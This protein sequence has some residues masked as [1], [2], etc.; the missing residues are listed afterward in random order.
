MK[1]ILPDMKIILDGIN[2]ILDIAK[3]NVSDLED[4]AIKNYP[5]WK[6]HKKIFKKMNRVSVLQDNFQVP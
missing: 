1:S 3:E 4:L 5:K 6:T 2:G